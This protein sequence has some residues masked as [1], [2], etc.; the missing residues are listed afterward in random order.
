MIPRIT[1]AILREVMTNYAAYLDTTFDV[2]IEGEDDMI[3]MNCD[4]ILA[5][6]YVSLEEK[7]A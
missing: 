2:V 5:E 7:A 6:F 1:T 3:V 4:E